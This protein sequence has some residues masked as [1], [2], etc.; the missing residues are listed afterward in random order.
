MGKYLSK[1]QNEET[2]SFFTIKTAFSKNIDLCFW[3]I[4]AADTPLCQWKSV[5][6]K[7]QPSLR[8]RFHVLKNIF[9]AFG[10][11]R[12]I[13][14][15]LPP[16]AATRPVCS[17]PLRLAS[18]FRIVLFFCAYPQLTRAYTV[19]VVCPGGVKGYCDCSTW[20]CAAF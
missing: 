2:V 1:F 4:I 7:K 18:V 6:G 5:S 11:F 17:A 14:Q 15:R 3:F 8:K 16:A 12:P 9:V 19:P 10:S 13:S 20:L